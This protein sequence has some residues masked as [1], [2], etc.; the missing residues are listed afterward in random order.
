MTNTVIDEAINEIVFVKKECLALLADLNEF[1]PPD[2]TGKYNETFRLMAVPMLYASWERCFTMCHSIALRVIRDMTKAAMDLNGPQRAIWLFQ[3]PFYQSY[4]AR[5]NKDSMDYANE[6][7][8]KGHFSNLSDFITK[9]D[10]WLKKSLDQSIAVEGLVMTC[11]NVNP[12][13][14]DINAQS[15]G[16]NEIRQYKA[17][18]LGRLH[19]LVGRRNGIGHGALIHPPSN[20]VFIDLWSFTETLIN[21][22]SNLFIEWLSSKYMKYEI[23]YPSP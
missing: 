22:Y 6:K 16:I 17:L 9:T 23:Y 18:R 4:I 15:I 8:K 10:E 20:D 19:D 3:T 1:S 13:V 12:D 5:V 7:I 11:S 2:A 21:D 14:V